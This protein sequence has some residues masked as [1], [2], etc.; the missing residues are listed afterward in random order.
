MNEKKLEESR[1]FENLKQAFLEEASLAQRYAYFAV[2][3][4]FEGSDR[5]SQL[6][7]EFA[8]SGE[9][10]SGGCL[11]FLRSGRELGG[12]RKNLQSVLQ[13]ESEHSNELYATMAR[14]AREEGFTDAASWFDTLEKLKRSRL[15][16]I[17]K[18]SDE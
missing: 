3:A 1:T 9:V 12:T 18:V 7:K 13:T 5:F 4:D 8:K 17:K 14:I 16:R 15:A 2:I 11:D 10:N 6:F